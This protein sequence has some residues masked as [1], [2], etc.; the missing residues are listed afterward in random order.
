MLPSQDDYLHEKNQKHLFALSCD[1]ADQRI[2]QSDWKWDTTGQVQPKM[3]DSGATFA[4]WD[5]FPC[6]KN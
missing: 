1:I 4:W 6:Q 5:T 2:L 3:I